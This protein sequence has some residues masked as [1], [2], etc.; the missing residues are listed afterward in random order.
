MG[1]HLALILHAHLP[2]VR[3]AGTEILEE[4]WL[5]EAVAETYVPLL[6]ALERL[7][8]DSVP[9]RLALSL[10]APLLAMLGDEAVMAACRR[11]LGR[12]CELAERE[13]ARHR[14]GPLGPAAL[15]H[16]RHYA[17]L[18]D[19]LDGC[20]GDLITRFRRLEEAGLVELFTAAGTHA[21]L[22]LLAT[23]ESRFAQIETGAAEFAARVGHR[24]GG[25]WLPECAYAPGLEHLLGAAGVRWFVAEGGAV[26]A[27]YPS[28]GG[29]VLLTPGGVAAFGRDAFA[30]RQVWDSSV[31]YPGDPVY[32]DFY[33]DVGYDLPLPEVAPWL[34]EGRVRAD[35]GLKFYR[36]TAAGAAQKEP[37]DPAAAALRVREHA[38]HFAGALRERTGLVVAPFDAELFGHWW[39]E[40]PQWIEA[41]FRELAAGA[42][43]AVTPGDWL[44][45]CGATLPV[46]R[47]PAS[48]WGAGGDYRVWLSAAN[49]WIYPELHAAERR[50]VALASES[51]AGS[52]RLNAAGR[53][54]MLA[55]ASDWPFILDGQTAVAYAR[56]ELRKHLDR[57]TA[58]ADGSAAG[59]VRG[60]DGAF[61]HVNARALWG[62][63]RAV[64]ATG[65]LRILMLSWEFPPNN[66][67][68]L[69][70]HVYDLGAALRRAGH[71]VS[72]VTL[73]DEGCSAAVETV[74]GMT[75]YR[76]ARPPE[77]GNFL[78]WVYRANQSM[79]AAALDADA[80]FDVVHSHDWLAGQAGMALKAR[81][82]VPL[83]ATIHATEKGRSGQITEPIQQAIHDEEWLLT[84]AADRVITVS[85]AMAAE[86]AESF[87]VA[88]AVIYNGVAVPGPT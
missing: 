13:A 77:Q 17:A 51:G 59:V 18:T 47:L 53:E 26:A 75:V 1:A 67:G 55:Q 71:A 25:M 29:S 40:G 50:L 20:G 49:D 80:P 73:A 19:Y 85:E 56:R 42:L 21:C 12:V 7:R 86:V 81:M 58:V 8:A 41:L 6:W 83:I 2:Y 31:G 27:S 10:S 60:A 22:P 37:Y 24:P 62:R 33:R 70:R 32:R 65:P 16:L 9:A 11:H 78:A 43:R 63:R 34:V 36:V 76:V 52:E 5:Y 64:P 28:A 14:G 39:F 84:A 88:P 45:S 4:R 35:T 72:V 15:H 79:V 69:G 48:T 57:F 82:R 74:E 23:D 54:L 87:R 68:G 44:D 61:P 38:A 3:P 46:G 66:V 30:T